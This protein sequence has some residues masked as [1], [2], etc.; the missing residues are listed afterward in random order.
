MSCQFYKLNPGDNFVVITLYLR[1]LKDI[2]SEQLDVPNQTYLCSL[3][4][5]Y[6]KI[7]LSL[8]S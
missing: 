4:K 6:I 5:D 3:I 7:N 1:K 8:F 2:E